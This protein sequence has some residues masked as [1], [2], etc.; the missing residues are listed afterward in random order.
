MPPK[1]LTKG[2]KSIKP[3]KRAYCFCEPACKRTLSSRQ[4]FPV[5]QIK[6]C[7]CKHNIQFGVLFSQTSVSL[8]QILSFH[9][10]IS[11]LFHRE[12]QLPDETAFPVI[13]YQQV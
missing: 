2:L 12:Y 6:V 1:F 5:R 10:L 8:F 7:E 13:H 4:R 9:A 3:Y 11:S